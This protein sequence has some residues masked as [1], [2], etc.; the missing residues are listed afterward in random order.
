MKADLKT[1]FTHGESSAY[2]SHDVV[3]QILQLPNSFGSPFV[4]H[5]SVFEYM[6][7]RRHETTLASLIKE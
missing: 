3:T 7:L 4:K 5:K 6:S 1:G 2:G